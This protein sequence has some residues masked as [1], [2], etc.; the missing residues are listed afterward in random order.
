M[1]NDKKIETVVLNT[2]EVKEINKI[3]DEMF[4]LFD[5]IMEDDT[6]DQEKQFK[7]FSDLFIKMYNLCVYSKDKGQSKLIELE[8][9]FKERSNEMKT[10]QANLQE[11]MNRA[12]QEEEKQDG[13][14][15]IQSIF[16]LFIII[17]LLCESIKEIIKDIKDPEKKDILEK[18]IKK[19]E[20]KIESSL[21][22][23]MSGLSGTG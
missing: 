1:A 10:M 7:E 4:Q 17:T 15:K 23:Y 6:G 8:T 11:N 2:S 9:Q 12:N 3:R 21:N 22:K 13:Y 16:F 18:L 14:Q 20:K 19:S 5:K